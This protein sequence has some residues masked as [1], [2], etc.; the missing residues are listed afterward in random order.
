MPPYQGGREERV[1]FVTGLLRPGRT[2]GELQSE[3]Y[4]KCS[5]APFLSVQGGGRVLVA[6]LSPTPAPLAPRTHS[7]LGRFQDALH[8]IEVIR[9][10]IDTFFPVLD[11]RYERLVDNLI[12]PSPETVSDATAASA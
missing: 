10:P 5:V 4:L 1:V 12:Y 7:V 9:E 2:L 8:D 3:L 6:T 11:H